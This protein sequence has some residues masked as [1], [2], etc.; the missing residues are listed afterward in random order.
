ME[1]KET[2]KGKLFQN[3]ERREKCNE[4]KK[5][6]EKELERKRRKRRIRRQ[7]EMRTVSTRSKQKSN[8]KGWKKGGKKRK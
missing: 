1:N 4:R 3:E 5:G 8:A 7:G 6:V 2:I